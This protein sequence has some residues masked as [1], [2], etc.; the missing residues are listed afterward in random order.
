MTIIQGV[1]GS[2]VGGSSGG[3]GGSKS[4]SNIWYTSASS[5]G[6]STD[7]NIDYN[8]W[9]G[10]PIYW[11]VVGKGWSPANPGVDFTGTL[12][13]TFT[14]MGTGTYTV[15][16]VSFVA[17]DTTEGD[18][19]WAVDA[20]ANPGGNDYWSGSVWTIN[21][22]STGPT[23]DL[24]SYSSSVNEGGSLGMVIATTKVADGTTLY[25]TVDY[26][27]SSASGDFGSTSGSFVVN[28]NYGTFSVPV[29][30]D[31]TTEGSQTFKV[32]I[33]TDSTSGT[34]VGTTSSI[35]INDTSLDPVPE[36]A[37]SI[38]SNGVGEGSSDQFTIT[39]AH[40]PDS[41]TLYWTIPD[42]LGIDY[43]DFTARNGAFTIT[44]NTGSFSV[45]AA[46][47]GL[48]EG[49][50]TFT[51]QIRTDS[52]TGNV[53]LTSDGVSITDNSYGVTSYTSFN[54][55]TGMV[56]T[57]AD[58]SNLNLGADYTI[59]WW[60]KVSHSQLSAGSWYCP[61]SQYAEGITSGYTFIDFVFNYGGGY[62]VMNGWYS[63]MNF[64]PS[65]GTWDHIA[66]SST[67]GH[68]K[69]YVNGTTVYDRGDLYMTMAN[70]TDLYIGKRGDTNYY[71]FPGKITGLQ[72]SNVGK[73][74]SNFTPSFPPTADANTVLR[75][76]PTQAST[77]GIT[78]SNGSQSSAYNC[79]IVRDA[80]A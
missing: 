64:T 74:S 65:N 31:S 68:V 18:E 29:T 23:Y 13:G 62:M 7:I 10:S 43:S 71:Q 25:W 54:T 34:V 30:A 4:I 61:V 48:T 80:P 36:Y 59:E 5:E 20:G 14:P 47:D 21:D 76:V 49:T 56:K 8:N 26:D 17:D 19:G 28:S 75:F 69:G 9:D 1:I 6:Y 40:V 44:G 63:S 78:S 55:A 2:I 24:G 22:L 70:T 45:E 41:T 60:Q 72:I 3:G 66:F 12:S 52:V 42:S 35:T 51:V 37:W 16:S 27:S 15:T 53:V 73:Y 33:R 50:Q 57:A 38:Y 77:L 79:E 32:Q 11:A 39:T 58:N 46:S 67:N